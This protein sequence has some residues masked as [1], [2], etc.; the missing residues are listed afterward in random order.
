[1]RWTNVMVLCNQSSFDWD[2]ET[3]M[4]TADP[5]V[6]FQC[7]IWRS[8]C[9]P[10]L[11]ELARSQT[12]LSHP[13]VSTAHIKNVTPANKKKKSKSKQ[14]LISLSSSSADEEDSKAKMTS[15]AA[16]KSVQSTTKRIRE[17]KGS[18]V[19]KSIDGLIGA[20]TQASL[21]LATS[22]SAPNATSL[23]TAYTRALE[24]LA[25]MFLDE[26]EDKLYI[27][28]FFYWRTKE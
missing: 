13:S 27:Q 22:I 20:I 8:V 21:S 17:S 14:P 10:G 25:E 9:L 5:K 28:F 6:L 2:N 15:D 23:D 19:T 7:I 24:S 18:V 12:D 3:S 16:T 26:V 11:L 4:V 1:R